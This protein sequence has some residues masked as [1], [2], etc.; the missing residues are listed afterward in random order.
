MVIRA[1][2]DFSPNRPRVS[3][4]YLGP[5]FANFRQFS[6]KT[7]FPRRIFA[8][9]GMT[10]S[11]PCGHNTAQPEINSEIRCQLQTWRV[12]ELRPDPSYVRHGCSVS[13][14]QMS[15]LAALG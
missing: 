1:I 14:S 11:Q 2:D 9:V 7:L 3:G 5:L 4:L 13:V 15:A 12:D 10:A 8:L 6:P